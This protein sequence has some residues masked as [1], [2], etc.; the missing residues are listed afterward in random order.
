MPAPLSLGL[1]WVGDEVVAE[2]AERAEAEE[3]A[4]RLE[5]DAA[6]GE[7]LATREAAELRARRERPARTGVATGREQQGR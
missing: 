3:E 4:A 6:E 2:E 5:L 1:S 7:A